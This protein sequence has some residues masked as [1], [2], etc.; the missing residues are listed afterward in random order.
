[1]IPIAIIPDD[2]IDI[3][4]QDEEPVPKEYR[5]YLSSI[6]NPS[7]LPKNLPVYQGT[8]GGYYIDS[9]ML[10]R[11]ALE[12]IGYMPEEEKPQ[13]TKPTEGQERIPEE[14]EER[15]KEP[16]EEKKPRRRKEKEEY[17][18]VLVRSTKKRYDDIR[19]D[20][21]KN[22]MVTNFVK[23][24]KKYTEEEFT[25]KVA[26]ASIAL[27]PEHTEAESVINTEEVLSVLEK[28]L[29]LL[30][31]GDR[32]HRLIKPE[33][34]EELLPYV[35][36]VKETI[37]FSQSVFEE[38]YGEETTVYR[39]LTESEQIQ[40]FMQTVVEGEKALE[41]PF[42]IG[43]AVVSTFAKKEAVEGFGVPV[44]EIKLRKENVISGHWMFS[45]ERAELQEIVALVPKEG[46]QISKIEFGGRALELPQFA[47]IQKGLEIAKA[48]A[49]KEIRS[50]YD[51]Y[52]TFRSVYN[53][54]VFSKAALYNSELFFK[55]YK[56]AIDI[57]KKGRKKTTHLGT[58]EERRYV[59]GLLK[60][61]TN[62]TQKSVLEAAMAKREIMAPD[63]YEELE[64]YVLRLRRQLREPSEVLA[65]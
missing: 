4:K 21:K 34:E 51:I 48:H 10:S 18:I 23:K 62:I 42:S 56:K 20:G 12:E 54:N 49:S 60:M 8:R 30:E 52:L 61:I 9:R 38:I 37:E 3:K 25:Q 64:N 45:P 13:E 31:E 19:K 1:M 58:F 32:Y 63:K 53:K 50:V 28:I 55:F 24:N 57:Y 44:A 11:E 33:N 15:G 27:S 16:K 43:G 7:K 2:E 47:P 65:P 29:G 14:Q 22:E 6:T 59:A 26:K 35:Q 17:D 46:F 40:M 41:K 36:E 5:I 39:P